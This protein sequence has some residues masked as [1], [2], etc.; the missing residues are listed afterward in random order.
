MK[1]KILADVVSLLNYPTIPHNI[2]CNT[3]GR[4]RENDDE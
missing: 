4:G 3:Q 1:I 2:C